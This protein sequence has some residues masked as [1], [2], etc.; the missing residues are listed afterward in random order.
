MSL[1]LEKNLSGQRSTV[2]SNHYGQ[3][4]LSRLIDTALSDARL[5]NKILYHACTRVDFTELKKGFLDWKPLWYMVG[6]ERLKRSTSGL[7]VIELVD[8]YLQVQAQIKLTLDPFQN[9][10][11]YL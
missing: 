7:K 1:R 6:R 2:T 9:L 4:N 5:L 11:K 3:R 10:I 8:A